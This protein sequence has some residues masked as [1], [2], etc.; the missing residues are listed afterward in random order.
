MSSGSGAGDGFVSVPIPRTVLERL[1]SIEEAPLRVLLFLFLEEARSR[2]FPVL[3]PVGR[4]ARGA[5]VSGPRARLALED[6]EHEGM[7]QRAPDGRY[8]LAGPAPRG[9]SGEAGRRG[10]SKRAPRPKEARP[11]VKCV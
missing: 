2:A 8:C 1:P 9:G 5:G 3:T 6:L 11:N 7:V 4:I 10:G